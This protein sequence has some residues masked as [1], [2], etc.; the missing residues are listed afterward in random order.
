MVSQIY[1][2]YPSTI[3]FILFSH[4]EVTTSPFGFYLILLRFC[5]SIIFIDISNISP[6]CWSV[7]KLP[8]NL[9]TLG[10]YV[11]THYVA[12]EKEVH[13]GSICNILQGVYQFENRKIYIFVLFS[14][15]N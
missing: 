14:R 9:G 4:G 11:L 12:V 3:C 7:V 13:F 5:M 6:T 8:E 2:V 15:K 10:K 1:Q